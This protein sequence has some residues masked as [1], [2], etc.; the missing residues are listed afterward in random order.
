MAVSGDIRKQSHFVV[1]QL[2]DAASQILGGHQLL[3]AGRTTVWI[4]GDLVIFSPR[5]AEA[6]RSLHCP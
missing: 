5:S 4:T 2:E 6:K 3:A 1:L